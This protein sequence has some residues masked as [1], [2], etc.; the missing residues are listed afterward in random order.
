MSF[1]QGFLLGLTTVI[2][3]GPVFFTIL[4]GTL[5]YGTRAGIIVSVGIVISDL[6]CVLLCS[7]AAP[8][9]TSPQANFWLALIG[10]LV[11]LGMGIKYLIKPIKYSGDQL[12]LN[13]KQSLQFFIKGFIVNFSS[14]FTFA[15]WLGAV[16]YSNNNYTSITDVVLFVTSALL[17]IFFIDVLK[18][19]L[20]KY[21]KK[22]VQPKTLKVISILCGIVLIGFAVRM[23]WYIYNQS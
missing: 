13:S 9:V 11:L 12:N 4:N 2:F 15:Y 5:Q 22:I 6:V 17:G 21:L 7:L 10:G 16:A 1:I 19:I 14:P 8:I 23:G 18:V 20:A 3:F